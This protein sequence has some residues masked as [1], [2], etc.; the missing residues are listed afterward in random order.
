MN[1]FDKSPRK[2]ED[3]FG[4]KIALAESKDSVSK[5]LVSIMVNERMIMNLEGL[6]SEAKRLG[7]NKAVTEQLHDVDFL[8]NEVVEEQQRELEE[9]LTQWTNTENSCR[10]LQSS[11][12]ILQEKGKITDG[13]LQKADDQYRR[14]LADFTATANEKATLQQK[15]SAISNELDSE[16]SSNENLQAYVSSLVLAVEANEMDVIHLSASTCALEAECQ[17]LREMLEAETSR[18]VAAEARDNVVRVSSQSQTETS[19]SKD[20]E[21][22]VE[23]QSVEYLAKQLADSREENWKLT[24]ELQLLRSEKAALERYYS[25]VSSVD[26]L[27]QSQVTEEYNSGVSSSQEQPQALES[28]SGSRLWKVARSAGKVARSASFLM[29]GGNVVPTQV[30]TRPFARSQSK[31][32][33]SLADLGVL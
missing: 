33:S 18:R 25:S 22:I 31:G 5:A 24:Q 14:L 11:V 30:L 8:L 3:Y 28:S 19:A 32:F 29:Q 20:V 7:K 26:A 16:K 10:L 15:L 13:K 21:N 9:M 27:S 6:K 12:A 17:I 23:V 2:T 4:S 1:S